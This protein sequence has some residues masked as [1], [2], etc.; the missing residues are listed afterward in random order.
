[1]SSLYRSRHGSSM[2]PTCDLV[3]RCCVLGGK[4]G[5]KR[6]WQEIQ[7]LAG[8]DS[9]AANKYTR[10]LTMHTS[11]FWRVQ[12]LAFHAASQPCHLRCASSHCLICIT[13]SV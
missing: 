12:R 10:T 8:S 11:T 6:C 5:C 1:V 13:S 9:S 4:H 2:L 3:Q 7:V